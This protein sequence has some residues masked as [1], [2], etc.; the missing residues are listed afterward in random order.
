MYGIY[1]HDNKNSRKENEK[2]DKST[3]L[4]MKRAKIFENK[5]S[6][7]DGRAR[8]RVQRKRVE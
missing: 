1:A 8:C 7:K 2:T 3:V 5:H 4:E 6:L